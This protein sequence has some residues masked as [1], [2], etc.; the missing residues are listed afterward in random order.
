MFP[1]SPS[2]VWS[3]TNN[4]TN[5]NNAVFKIRIIENLAEANFNPVP[6][7]C[8]PY[9]VQFENTSQGTSFQWNFGDGTTST[10]TN[11]SHTYTEGGTFTVTLIASDPASCNRTDTIRRTVTVVSPS[12]ST[13][14]D[15]TSCP[16]ESV[17]IGPETDYPEG[18]TFEWIQGSGFSNP[19]SQNPS[20]NNQKIKYT[21]HECLSIRGLF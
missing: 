16:G 20:V 9:N 8:A 6:V 4:S 15:I 18:T 17:I 1:M 7:G 2:D 19:H 14:A 5:C 21:H 11:P 10:Q 13:L 3:S 12:P